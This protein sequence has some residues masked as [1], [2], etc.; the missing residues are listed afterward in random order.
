MAQ[1]GIFAEDKRRWTNGCR[2]SR[3]ASSPLYGY[4]TMKINGTRP[5]GRGAVGR[6]M[7]QPFEKMNN[8]P[9]K[10]SRVTF[11]RYL[12]EMG[13]DGSLRVLFRRGLEYS[14]FGVESYMFEDV[15][16]G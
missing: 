6:W 13:R 3:T 15:G 10:S 16:S 8:Y 9:R 4:D 12:I 1:K 11:Y 14:I 7:G 2:A 5:V